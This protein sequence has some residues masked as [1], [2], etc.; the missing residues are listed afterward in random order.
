LVNN[1]EVLDDLGRFLPRV[2]QLLE[3]VQASCERTPPVLR[4]PCS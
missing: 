4:Y 3:Q 1:P 2:I